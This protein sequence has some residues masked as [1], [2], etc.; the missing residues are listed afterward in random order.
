MVMKEAEAKARAAAN[1][2]S[3]GQQQQP[4]QESSSNPF[5]LTLLCSSTEAAAFQPTSAIQHLKNSRVQCF[6]N[7]ERT[8]RLLGKDGKH[9][10]ERGVEGVHVFL[11]SVA[12]TYCNLRK[13]KRKTSPQ[14]LWTTEQLSQV[15]CRGRR[16]TQSF[17]QSPCSTA[18]HRQRS[19]LGPESPHGLCL[20]Q[21]PPV[22]HMN[23]IGLTESVPFPKL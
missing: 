2:S 11:T 20:V 15:H 17:P 21:N 12:R 1:A 13:N 6:E 22:R 3:L 16:K 7:R 4:L 5:C 14:S 23:H 10:W 19:R 8:L 9:R 18:R